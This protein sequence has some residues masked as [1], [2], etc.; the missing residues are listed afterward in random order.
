MKH[1]PKA[2][3][4]DGFGQDRLAIPADVAGFGLFDAGGDAQEGAL[5]AARCAQQADRLTRIHAQGE[6]AQERPGFVLLVEVD[7][8][9]HISLGYC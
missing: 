3:A 5:A 8:F 1:E 9:K 7:Y 6:V 2:A 4:V